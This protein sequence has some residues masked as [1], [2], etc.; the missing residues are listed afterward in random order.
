MMLALAKAV[1]LEAKLFRGFAEPSRLAIL[2]ALQ[3]GPKT[4]TELVALT[5]LSQPNTSNHLAC[6]RECALVRAE[7]DGRLVRYELADGRVARILQTARGLLSDV[8]DEI[9]DCVNDDGKGR[10]KRG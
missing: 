5:G 1:E 2:T 9:R 6:L 7:A 8:A 10:R 3:E 4:V